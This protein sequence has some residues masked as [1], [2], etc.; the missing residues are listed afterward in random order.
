MS[1]YK[2]NETETTK[3]LETY[4]K[5]FQDGWNLAMKQA[6]EEMKDYTE[7]NNG[8]I[9][10]TL[11]STPGMDAPWGPKDY[12][13]WPACPVCGKS[14]IRHEVCYSAAC[15]SRVAYGP[16]TTT[17]TSITGTYEGYDFGTG[18]IGAAGKDH[19]YLSD[20]PLGANGPTGG[21]VK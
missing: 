3:N 17:G 18:A 11:P 2:I 19:D 16:V 14:G 20:Y 7:K 5:G 13:K 10:P 21:D 6:K 9:Y 8:K 1:E 15:P 12:S 4:A